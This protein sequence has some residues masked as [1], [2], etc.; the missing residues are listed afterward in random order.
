M[1]KL[2]V[3]DIFDVKLDADGAIFEVN[4]GQCIAV[5][6][7]TDI[8]DEELSVLRKEPLDCRLSTIDGIIFIS[9]SFGKKMIFNMPFN[10]CLYSQFT[11]KSPYPYGYI[12]PIVI[13]ENSTNI[14][15]ARVLGWDNDFSFRFYKLCE[16][17]LAKGVENYD[18][19]L[20]KIY[21]TYS[22][23][24]ILNRGL[25]VNKLR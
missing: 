13:V 20:N 8:T 10:I 19:R 24:E 6:G 17:Q 23:I 16:T 21:N 5:I 15:K 2:S 22:E 12:I 4:D 11:L 18:Q 7:L 9:F 25:I 14:I 3:G 1:K